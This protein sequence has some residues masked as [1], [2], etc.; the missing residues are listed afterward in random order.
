VKLKKASPDKQI[1]RIREHFHNG[2]FVKELRKLSFT[3]QNNP[4]LLAEM[5]ALRQVALWRD[6]SFRL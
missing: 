3:S 1:T 5:I 2:V 4:S 6:V